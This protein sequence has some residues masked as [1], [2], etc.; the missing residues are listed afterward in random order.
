MCAFTA[1]HV[2]KEMYF[3]SSKVALADLHRE[4]RFSQSLQHRHHILRV[5]FECGGVDDD[6]ID[7]NE[8]DGPVQTG[9][10]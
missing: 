8:A 1:H 9:K 2:S 5:L 7:V 3:P 10:H 6:I 4:I